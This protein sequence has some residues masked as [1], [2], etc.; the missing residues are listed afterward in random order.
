MRNLSICA[1]C[2]H[3]IKKGTGKYITMKA[4]DDWERV[5]QVH[6]HCYLKPE[7]AFATK[8]DKDK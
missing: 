8:G 4:E 5:A 3:P 2:H 7:P 1:M 6:L